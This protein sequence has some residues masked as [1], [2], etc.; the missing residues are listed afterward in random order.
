MDNKH[1]KKELNTCRRIQVNFK[2]TQWWFWK[3]PLPEP[4]KPSTLWTSFL[5][6]VLQ[7]SEQFY[8]AASAGPHQHLD[9]GKTEQPG[10]LLL[11]LLAEKPGVLLCF[12]RRA[13]Q[14]QGSHISYNHKII[15]VG[16][17]LW[18][19]QVQPLS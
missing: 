3:L 5:T 6:H 19:V 8:R 9:P 17:D 16:K 10:V 4:W 2:C 1:I 15:N 7:S 18:D 14:E 11:A 12:S 13:S